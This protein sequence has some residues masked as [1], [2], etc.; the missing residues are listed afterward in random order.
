MTDKGRN[1]EAGNLQEGKRVIHSRAVRRAKGTRDSS[2]GFPG[3][4][5]YWGFSLGYQKRI[6]QC[7]RRVPEGA[8]NEG[9]LPVPWGATVVEQMQRETPKLYPKDQDQNFWEL[10]KET[11]KGVLITEK[12]EQVARSEQVAGKE[13][14]RVTNRPR[15]QL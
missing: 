10:P 2:R 4:R 13:A 12:S 15:I 1:G 8:P 9:E 3:H 5:K 14:V 7:F 6:S 11:G